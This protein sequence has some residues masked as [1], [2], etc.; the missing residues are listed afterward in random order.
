MTA[1]RTAAFIIVLTFF[2]IA[3]VVSQGQNQSRSN[4][5]VI[6]VQSS[7]S[8]LM[9][10]T[11]RWMGH[12]PEILQTLQSENPTPL[13]T[14]QVNSPQKSHQKQAFDSIAGPAQ[15]SHPLKLRMPSI[16]I[17]SPSGASLYYGTNSA[18]NAAF[19]RAI[20]HGDLFKNLPKP[21]Q[22]RPTLQEAMSILPELKRYS[23][24][25]QGNKKYT[26]LAMTYPG[27]G[28]CE[29]Q[30]EAMEQLNHRVR[31][32]GIRVIEVQLHR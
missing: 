31:T 10:G 5:A 20:R 2:P 32:L 12:H 27:T 18:R 21:I 30:N 28:M 16:D 29:A 14:F 3:S 1:L 26:I 8:E 15:P 11:L 17:Y 9:A 7:V 23:S 19:I 25:L 24:I 13:Q 6:T 4:D 22:L